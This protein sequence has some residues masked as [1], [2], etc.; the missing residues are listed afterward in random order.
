M[1]PPSPPSP[2]AIGSLGAG[3][4]YTDVF[5]GL[6][7]PLCSQ[8]RRSV[9]SWCTVHYRTAHYRTASDSGII[10]AD[11]IIMRYLLATDMARTLSRLAQ[12][13]SGLGLL[14]PALEAKTL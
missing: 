14:S 4:P 2:Q 5:D 8:P 12:Q 11:I 6:T 9:P 3:A 1:S 10:H 7:H 13:V